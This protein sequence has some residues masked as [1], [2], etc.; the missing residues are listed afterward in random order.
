[1]KPPS[2]SPCAT[3][4]S[5]D[6]PAKA[7]SHRKRNVSVQ[8]PR[9]VVADV[10]LSFSRSPPASAPGALAGGERLNEAIPVVADFGL[11]KRV[12]QDGALTQSGAVVGT[13][14]YMAPE[15]ALAAKGLSTTVADARFAKPLDRDLVRV[16]IE[17]S[18]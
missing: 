18:K 8:N 6:P 5:I 10:A 3:T 2:T 16:Q 13:P 17:L 1:M 15:Q 4:A 14:A 9:K 12:A 11:A 7:M